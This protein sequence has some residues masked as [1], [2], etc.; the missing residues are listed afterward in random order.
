MVKYILTAPQSVRRSLFIAGII[1]S[2]TACAAPPSTPSALPS[3]AATHIPTAT[4]PPTDAAQPTDLPPAQT[5]TPAA[6]NPISQPSQPTSY[7]VPY[8]AA[9][10]DMVARLNEWR[11]GLGLWP[12]RINETLRSVAQA[13]AQYLISLPALPDDIHDGPGGQPPE[14]AKGLGWPA[15]SNDQQIA[16]SEIGYAG[17]TPQAAIDY[18]HQSSIHNQTVSSEAYREVGVAIVPQEWGHLYIVVF[19]S[20]PGVLTALLDPLG[21]TLY[22]SSERYRWASSGTW[23]HDVIQVQVAAALDENAWLPWQLSLSAPSFSE[24]L[25]V[26]FTDGFTRASIQLHLPDD[27][28]WLPQNLSLAGQPAAAAS[29]D[30][31]IVYDAQT[32]SIVNTS[33]EPADVAQLKLSGGGHWLTGSL[34][35]SEWLDAPLDAFPAQD[36]LQVWAFGVYDPGQPEMCQFRRSVIY[37]QP[38]NL[39]WANFD[40]EVSWQGTPLTTCPAG[41][42]RCDITLP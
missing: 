2:L 24:A 36:C 22:L 5:A 1:A 25:T 41:E 21:N 31:A 8:D 33:A 20:R 23:I 27:I 6:S 16:V 35:Q 30:L 9:E 32:L 34:W 42:G 28:A 19:G 12:L 13:Q 37:L 11:I 38:E 7:A 39:F 15:Y 26:F 4:L 29:A 40:F 14:R 17:A 10:L 18:W 3:A